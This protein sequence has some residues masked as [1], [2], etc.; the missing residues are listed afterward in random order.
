MD[1]QLRKDTSSLCRSMTRDCNSNAVKGSLFHFDL[2]ATANARSAH[3]LLCRGM[4]TSLSS[5]RDRRPAGLR[6]AS[7]D[8]TA[9]SIENGAET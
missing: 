6:D 8:G 7:A 2:Q 9:R 1:I 4:T 5:D 3:L